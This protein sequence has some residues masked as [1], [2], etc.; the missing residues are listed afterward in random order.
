MKFQFLGTSAGEQFPALWCRCDICEKARRLSGRNI[1]TNSHAFL[2]PDTLIDLPPEAFAQIRRFDVPIFDIEHL[3]ITHSH[4]D[5]FCP[6]LLA[7]RRMNEDQELPPPPG[8][9]GPRFSELRTL[10]VYGNRVVYQQL[11]GMVGEGK[12]HAMALHLAEPFVD[13]DAGDM[14]V[15]PLLANHV[16]HEGAPPLNYIIRRGEKTL[17][18]ALDTGWFLDETLAAIRRDQYDLVVLDGTYAQGV[19]AESH[20]NFAKVEKALALFRKEG[21]LK[22][23]AAFCV[24]HTGPHFGPVH[25]E[26]APIMAEKGITIAYDGMEISL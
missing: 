21:L 10:H 26:I 11:K 18:Y 16:D 8:A 24:S 19:D 1:R 3:F 13:F 25:D 7:W 6:F 4:E 2:A 5:H 15:T 23:G 20:N 22:D 12:P 17:L 14:R 9:S